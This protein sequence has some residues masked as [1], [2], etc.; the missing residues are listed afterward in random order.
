VVILQHNPARKRFK[1][2]ED[3]PA[4]IAPIK[5][6][7]DLIRIYGANTVAITV[8]TDKMTAADARAYAAEQEKA[9]GIPVILP[10]EDGVDK[11]IPI[12]KDL[13]DK[14]IAQV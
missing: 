13:I 10:L 1:G 7:I 11:L 8:N 3:Y 2:L 12:F 6:E 9:L 5:D 4:D 14:S